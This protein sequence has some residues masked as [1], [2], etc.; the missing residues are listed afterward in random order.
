MSYWQWLFLL[1]WPVSVFYSQINVQSNYITSRVFWSS[2]MMVALL[3]MLFIDGLIMTYYYKGGIFPRIYLW[4]II[5]VAYT[6]TGQELRNNVRFT[7]SRN[8]TNLRISEVV[9]SDAGRYECQAANTLSTI[10]TYA[11][12]TIRPQGRW[13]M[14]SVWWLNISMTYY[15]IFSTLLDILFGPALDVT[16]K[17]W[18]NLTVQLDGQ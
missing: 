15:I 3:C 11:F 16:S 7:I 5:T 13:N 9:S 8:S 14:M 1:E 6:L 17:T 2:F 4:T 18:L 12:L 10:S